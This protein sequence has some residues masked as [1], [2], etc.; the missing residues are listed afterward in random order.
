[1]SE[2]QQQYVISIMCRDRVGLIYEISNAIAELKGNIADVRQS[3][4]CGYF[5]MILLASFPKNV[6]QRMIERK[7][8]EVDSKSETVID[9]A[10]AKVAETIQ[11]SVS[12]EP[13]NAYVLTATGNDRIGLVAAVAHFC[14]KNDINILDLSTTVS[15]GEYVMILLVDLDHC[16]SIGQVRADLQQYAHENGLKV[17]MQHHHIFKAINEINLPLL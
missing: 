12:A 14:A 9:A 1:M 3:V 5:T 11:P 16:D 13:E 4:L 7:F 10:V 15:D 8:A 2:N 6:S 17:V